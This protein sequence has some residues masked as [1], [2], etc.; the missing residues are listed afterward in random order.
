VKA[1]LARQGDVGWRHSGVMTGWVAKAQ[2][3]GSSALISRPALMCL[4]DH[5]EG[6]SGQRSQTVT[7]ATQAQIQRESSGG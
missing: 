6:A 3:S 4:A 2:D 1:T 7:S 5:Q